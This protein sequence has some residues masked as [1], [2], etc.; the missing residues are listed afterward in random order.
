MSKVRDFNLIKA[1]EVNA[2]ST[3]TNSVSVV[4]NADTSGQTNNQAVQP[5]PYPQPNFTTAQS[6]EVCYAQS[7]LPREA[8]VDLQQES[9]IEDLENE[10]E[11]YKLL[12][13]ILS[14]ILKD[15]NPK[16]IINLIDQSGKIIVHGEEL[17]KLIAVKTR[18]SESDINLRYKDEEP[19]CLSKVSPIKDISD[20]K[21]NNETFSLKFNADYNVI[22]DNFNI[23]LDKVIITPSITYGK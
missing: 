13:T 19:T 9:Q 10:L 17:I 16:L 6:G 18:K 7:I 2:T 12:A 8:N 11:F 15:N 21:I 3:N 22:K 4:V 20:I 14:D 23:S 5:S 1:G